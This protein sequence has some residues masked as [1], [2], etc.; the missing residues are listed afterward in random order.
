LVEK[1]KKD[2]IKIGEGIVGAVA[3]KGEPLLIEDATSDPRVPKSSGDFL[4]MK[5]L[6]LAPLRVRDKIV[7]VFVVV[8]KKD[9]QHFNSRDMQLLQAL[10]DQAAV[11][12][13]IVSLYEELKEKHR[14]EQE[15]SLAR[16]FQNLLLPKK[17]PDLPGLDLAAF[18][19]PAL[20]VGGDYYDFITV[21]ENH[22]GVVIADVSGKGIPGALL[23]AMVRSTLRAEAVGKLSPKEVL[24]RVND[25]VF[26]DTKENVFI[27]MTYGVLDLRTH[28][29]RMVRAG[30]EPT[31][32]FRSGDPTPALVVPDGIALGLVGGELFDVM[33]ETQVDLSSGDMVVLYTDGVIEAMNERAQEYGRERLL[34]LVQKESELPTTEIIAKVL[35]DIEHFT[36]GIPQHDDI[37]MVVIKA[38]DLAGWEKDARAVMGNAG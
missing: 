27:T 22:L 14:M 12:V 9:D 5:S 37:T 17:C 2:K 13:D 19:T 26:K 10:A 7:G 38:R 24:R 34:E 28:R 36:E 8:N 15:L 29:M 11:T 1:V 21:D 18:N 25:R 20:E 31:I 32:T 35:G 23:M 6:M 33:E 3:E 16:E 4:T 30:H